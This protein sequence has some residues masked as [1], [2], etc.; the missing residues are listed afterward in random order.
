M[1]ENVKINSE[2]F[3]LTK[4]TL[5]VKEVAQICKKYN[6]KISLRETNDEIPNLGFFFKQKIIKNWF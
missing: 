3:N 2:T 6:K 1:E 5:T 4:D